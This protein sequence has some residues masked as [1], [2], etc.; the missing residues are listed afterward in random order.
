M[1]EAQGDTKECPFCAETIKAK[2]VKCKHCGSMLN[3]NEPV[4]LSKSSPPPQELS[5]LKSSEV[6]EKKEKIFLQEGNVLVSNSRVVINNKTYS[7]PNITSVSSSKTTPPNTMKDFG[8]A[9]MLFGGLLALGTIWIFFDETSREP[10]FAPA[11]T[12]TLILIIPAIFFLRAEQPKSIYHL[13]IVSASR[14]I[15]A[16][17]AENEEY[18]QKI[19]NAINDAM[20]Y[21]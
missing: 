13:I 10:M 2:A 19:I 5:S 18:I 16:L 14:E 1:S 12:L 21:R 15:Q 20:K 11:L 4:S 9:L 8:M 6:E 3:E 7:L 17:T